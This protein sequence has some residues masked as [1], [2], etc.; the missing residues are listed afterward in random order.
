MLVQKRLLSTT[1]CKLNILSCLQ[2]GVSPI[3]SAIQI[4]VSASCEKNCLHDI[5]LVNSQPHSETLNVEI[6]L[7]HSAQAEN[8][9]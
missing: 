6:C 1:S 2:G 7:F 5:N 3:V 9:M 8:V 4:A